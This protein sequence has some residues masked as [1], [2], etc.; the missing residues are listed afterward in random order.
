MEDKKLSI[1]SP[2][3][4]SGCTSDRGRPDL[5]LDPQYYDDVT[6]HIDHIIHYG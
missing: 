3:G 2:I 1:S 4:I 5:D 6:S